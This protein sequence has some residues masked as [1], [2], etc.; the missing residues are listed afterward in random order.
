[1]A[2]PLIPTPGSFLDRIERLF[3]TFLA[4]LSSAASGVGDF[5]KK[6]V[7][8]WIQL[9]IIN[10][11]E[12]AAPLIEQAAKA[13]TP[14]VNEI[15]RVV[16]SDGPA[17]VDLV[18]PPIAGLAKGV[19]S[20]SATGLTSTGESTPDKALDTAAAAFAD[21]FGFGVASS[22]TAAAFEAALPEKLNVLNGMAPLLAKMAG[23]D[24]VS[25]EV[26]AP[27]YKNAF[28]RSLDYHFR[29]VFKPELPS[30]GDAVTWHARRLLTDDQLR[31]V[32]GFSGLKDEYEAPFIQGAYRALQPRMFATLF[33]DVEFETDKVKHALEFAGIRDQEIEWLLPAL[34]RSSEK[35]VRQQYLSAVVRASELG[36]LTDA[37]LDAALHELEFSDEAAHWVRKTITTRK[38]E[39]LTELY[40]KSVSVAYEFGTVTD[41]DYVAELEAIGINQADAQAHYSID[42]A[43]KHGKE[44]RAAAAAAVREQHFIDR[45]AWAAA[46]AEFHGGI[47]DTITLAARFAAANMPAAA[48]PF[49]VELETLRVKSNKHYVY[50]AFVTPSQAILLREQVAAL[51]E[52]RI[53]GLIDDSTALAQL[54]S[55]NVPD[56]N[57][58]DLV[59]EWAAQ[60][61]KL[62]RPIS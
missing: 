54:A 10:G 36:T 27:L 45:A 14:I 51:K 16:K 34:K 32:F 47:L 49:A 25:H 21:A 53:K 29:S 6:A 24:E 20:A 35:N 17:I 59:A 57:A 56:K 62:L 4:F 55:F 38:L 39:Q 12:L 19:F 31:K 41:A 9:F 3:K 18:R 44:A 26:L 46:R 8:Q 2:A 37:E 52:Q 13:L 7:T 28:G 15:T 23:F 58:A 43:K 60:A 48:I 5:W 1:M 50:G 30:E 11:I 22:A 42:S 61:D 33:Q 40:R